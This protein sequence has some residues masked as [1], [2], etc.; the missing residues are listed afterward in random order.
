MSFWQA[1]RLSTANLFN[2]QQSDPADERIIHASEYRLS[3]TPLDVPPPTRQPAGSTAGPKPSHP[4]PPP[5]QSPGTPQTPGTV[6]SSSTLEISDPN[7]VERTLHV[8]WD[9]VAGTFRGLPACW[10]D[11]LPKGTVSSPTKYGV[12]QSERDG[13]ILPVKPTR[14]IRN[15]VVAG[16]G[17]PPKGTPL[18]AKQPSGGKQASFVK[19]MS[20]VLTEALQ[21]LGSSSA[22]ISSPNTIIGTPFNVKHNEHVTPDPTSE[23]GFKGLPAAWVALLKSSGITKEDAV[24]NPQAVLDCLTFHIEGPPPPV[25][26]EKKLNADIARTVHIKSD[27]PLK[28]FAHLR[29]LGS[30]AS[31]TVYSALDTRNNKSVALKVAP[32]SE[33]IELTN[34]IAMQA[35]SQHSNIVSYIETFATSSE[36]CIVMEYIQGGSLTDSIGIKIDFPEAHLANVCKQTLMALAHVHRSHRIHRD[37]KSDNILIDQA[38]GVVKIADFGFAI[39]LTSDATKRTSVVGTPYWM[40]PELIRGQDYGCEVDIWSL[41]ITAI[42]MAEGE[43]PMMREPPLRALLMITVKP[44]PKLKKPE[45]YSEIF[46]HFLACCLKTNP[47]ERPSAEQLLMHPFIAGASSNEE[48]GK[49]ATATIKAKKEARRARKAG[50]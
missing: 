23:T 21:N 11:L 8:E 46:S 39:G 41:G 3:A 31:G 10:A 20:V 27:D 4:P 38:S 44:A 16:H 42:E 28:Y 7:S 18:L 34:E 47:A 33:L 19:R 32:I 22:D 48:F 13:K 30:G 14:R 17:L 50:K 9:P 25:P 6:T 29:K 26:T 35:M 2:H 36:I 43:P 1:I 15:S 12:D 37:I 5:P 40:A 24:A 45:R 49:F